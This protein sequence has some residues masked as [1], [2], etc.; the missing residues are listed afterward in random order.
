MAYQITYGPVKQKRA[1][2]K[3]GRGKVLAAIFLAAL[4]L[5]FLVS[6][7][8]EQIAAFLLPGDPDVTAAALQDMAVQIGAG[9]NIGDAFTC[10]CQEIIENAGIAE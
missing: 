3:N 4:I 2:A 7:Y 8:R 6:G 5:S 9:E 1:A 10:F